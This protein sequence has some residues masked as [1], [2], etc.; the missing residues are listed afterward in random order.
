M[1]SKE[2]IKEFHIALEEDYG[3]TITLEEAE[4][5]L[6]GT[7]K[8]IDLLAQIEDRFLTRVYSTFF[9]TEITCC[10]YISPSFP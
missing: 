3:R 7:V 8:Y 6:R 2:T 1:I 5:I 9:D 4:S 10:I